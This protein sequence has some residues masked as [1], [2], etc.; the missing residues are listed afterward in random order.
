MITQYNLCTCVR[1]KCL[2][3]LISERPF[4]LDLSA[5]QAASVVI[6]VFS[7]VRVMGT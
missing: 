2:G 5:D 6:S 4:H 1:D 7:A 3:A